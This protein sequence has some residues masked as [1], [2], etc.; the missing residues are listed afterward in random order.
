MNKMQSRVQVV[1]DAADGGMSTGGSTEGG[2]TPAARR[3][4]FTD[5]ALCLA[6]GLDAAA[7]FSL[8]KTA[9]VGLKVR[10]RRLHCSYNP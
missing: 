1:N 2:D 7:L 4:T 9:A 10:S 3:G 6:G 8:F 5:L